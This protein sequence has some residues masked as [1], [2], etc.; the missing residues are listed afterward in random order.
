MHVEKNICENILGTILGI[1]GKSKDTIKARLD[2]KDMNIRKKLY[3]K[4]K[5][6]GSYL[7]PLACYTMSKKEK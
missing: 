5:G 6:D 4:R 3:L 2:L 7:V 1:D